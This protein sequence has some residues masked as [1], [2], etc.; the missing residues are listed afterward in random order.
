MISLSLYKIELYCI[1]HAD[2]TLVICYGA[3]KKFEKN[4]LTNIQ[5]LKNC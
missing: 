5:H 1:N 2:C 3:R 4:I